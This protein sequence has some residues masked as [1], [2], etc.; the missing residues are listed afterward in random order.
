MNKFVCYALTQKTPSTVDDVLP[1]LS[2][3]NV[4]SNVDSKNGF[5]Y[6]ELD[7]QSSR[8]TTFNSPFERFCWRRLPFG[9]VTAAE[10]VHTNTYLLTYPPTLL[11]HPHGA[12]QSQC[13]ITKF[14][15]AESQIHDND[16][17]K[18]R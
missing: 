7:D 17:L 5:W 11:D 18:K 1:D 6:V 8:L 14:K 15:N 12:F 16:N 2:R 13:Y 3:E 10:S 9:C 4:F